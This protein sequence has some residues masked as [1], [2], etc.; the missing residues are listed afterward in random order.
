MGLI[1]MQANREEDFDLARK[2]LLAYSADIGVDLGFQDF[3]KELEE[4]STLYAKPNGAFVLAFFDHSLIGCFGIRKI[5]D[6]T[7]ELKRMYLSKELRGRGLGEKLLL[8]ALEIARLSG[9]QHMRLDTLPSMQSAFG[10]YQKLGFREIEPYRFNPIAGSKFLEV[11]HL[12]N[13]GAWMKE[14]DQQTSNK[15]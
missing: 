6:K 1:I 5:D 3:E 9:Y 11:D 10:L 13:A 15:N 14:I 12:E 7:C 2:L 4:L 8:K